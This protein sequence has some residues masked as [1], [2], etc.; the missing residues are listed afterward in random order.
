MSEVD[1]DSKEDVIRQVMGVRVSP[2]REKHGKNTAV[3]GK[4]GTFREQ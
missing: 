2:V 3:M 1:L 4:E